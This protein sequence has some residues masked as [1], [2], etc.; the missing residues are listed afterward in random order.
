MLSEVYSIFFV[1]SVLLTIVGKIKS[2]LLYKIFKPVAS[3]LVILTPIITSEGYITKYDYLLL[4]GFIFAFIGD[5]LLVNQNKFF[6]YA[7]L[8]FSITH[9]FYSAAFLNQASFINYYYTVPFVLFAA[10]VYN[11]LSGDLFSEKPFVILYIVI[12]SVMGFSAVNLSDQFNS[13]GNYI[14]IGAIL[15]ITSDTLLAINKFKQQFKSAHVWILSTYY[16]GQFLIAL[17]V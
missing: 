13:T 3:I 6:R 1:C 8:S 7:L 14:L 17:S 4:L 10:G 11:Y 2:S 15:F 9:I 5:M 12:I 16:A